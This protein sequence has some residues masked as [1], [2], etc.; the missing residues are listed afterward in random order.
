[1]ITSI[2][3]I[4]V[5]A[6]VAYPIIGPDYAPSESP[7]I[8]L[9]TT[10]LTIGDYGERTFIVNS[11][12]LSYLKGT[13]VRATSIA[14]GAWMEGVVAAYVGNSLTVYLDRAYGSGT[15]NDWT[16]N[17][18]GTERPAQIFTP[19][20]IDAK[21]IETHDLSGNVTFMLKTLQGNDPTPDNP[22]LFMTPTGTFR[23]ILTAM[24]LTMT[25]GTYL[26]VTLANQPFRLWFLLIDETGFDPRLAL[27]QTRSESV[28]VGFPSNGLITT[29]TSGASS[30]PNYY[31]DKTM[32]NQPYLVLG[33][34]DYDSGLATAGVW[35]Q[36]PDRIHMYATGMPLPG[37][38]IQVVFSTNSAWA[39][40][41]A[42]IPLD[43]TIPQ[44]TE[45]GQF[46]SLA[47]TPQ[48]PSSVIFVEASAMLSIQGLTALFRSGQ[49][50]ALVSSWQDPNAAM[51]PELLSHRLY[52]GNTTASTFTFRAGQSS[53]GPTDF[54]GFG[55]A[56][57]YGGVANSWMR[58]AE[59]MT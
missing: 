18:C 2:S 38:M 52:L 55:S 39:T 32:T 23:Q 56:R 54:N 49:A 53:A 43:N 51:S 19:S 37:D 24:S 44:N 28:I 7:Y 17:V 27:A 31:S 59:L 20:A 36:S 57:Y 16:L 3:T 22:I 4:R 47:I 25:T 46:L 9:S 42:A 26:G 14:S 41:S 1:V 15:Y 33:Y 11:T 34:A 21:I 5:G 40:T 50:D 48:S 8:T 10:S 30:A 6:D 58:I 35:V 29:S 12:F 13:R 45:G